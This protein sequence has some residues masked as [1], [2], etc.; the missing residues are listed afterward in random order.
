MTDKVSGPGSVSI[1]TIMASL[2]AE[3]AEEVTAH[4]GK[5]GEEAI[6]QAVRNF[7]EKRGRDIASNVQAAGEEIKA[8]NYLPYYDM[9]RSELFKYENTYQP[10][11]VKQ[12]FSDCIFATAW[13]E[14]GQEKLGLLYCE[15]IDPAIARGYHSKFKC[16]HDKYLLKGDGCC[17][18]V[19][20]MEDSD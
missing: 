14:M 16:H 8:E 19:F 4:F 6:R 3:I 10:G 17:N 5:E 20:K 15:E 9:E 13:R 18:F 11:Q 7:G 12:H 1:Y 2:F